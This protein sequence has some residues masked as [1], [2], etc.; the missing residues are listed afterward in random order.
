MDERDLQYVPPTRILVLLEASEF[1]IIVVL[2]R[3]SF[4]MFLIFRLIACEIESVFKHI[5]G[6]LHCTS[7][8]TNKVTLELMLLQSFGRLLMPERDFIWV[9]VQTNLSS[10][11]QDPAAKL[12]LVMSPSTTED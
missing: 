8:G 6:F 7:L 4:W 2:Q 1:C 5:N 9:T 3:I 10:F 11:G 12:I